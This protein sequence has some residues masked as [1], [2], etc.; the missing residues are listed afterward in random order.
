MNR[1]KCDV[2][3]YIHFLVA[4]QKS[5]TCSESARCQPESAQSPS[6]DAFARLLRRQPPDTE[7][8]WQETRG[9]IRPQDGVWSWMTLL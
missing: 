3:D 2:L 4:A 9:L 6:H 7:A 8:L 1:A 5:F